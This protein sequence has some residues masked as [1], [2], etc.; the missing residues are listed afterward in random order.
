MPDVAQITS[1]PRTPRTVHLLV[2]ALIALALVL[3]TG[4]AA[5]AAMT[6]RAQW[7]MSSLPTMIDSAGGDNNGSTK[8]ITS[9]GSGL[10]SFNGRSSLATVP[11]KA[12]LDPG[13]ATIKLTARVRFSALPPVKDTF[14]IVRKGVTTTSGGNYKMEIYRRKTGAA[15][16]ACSFKGANGVSGQSYGTVNLAGTGFQTITCIKTASTIQ[17]IAAGQTRTSDKAVGSISNAS[18]VYVGGKGDGTDVFDGVMDFVKI[19]IG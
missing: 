8:N 13:S 11:D 19:E 3:T 7:D 14:D 9:G 1:V 10:Y 18:P 5:Q 4:V 6:V 16:A 15:V 17:V 12:N 2:S